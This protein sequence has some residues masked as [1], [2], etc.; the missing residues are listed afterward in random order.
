MKMENDLFYN[1]NNYKIKVFF[2]NINAFILLGTKKK[3]SY[4]NRLFLLLYL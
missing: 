4:V 2:I 3:K 1:Y